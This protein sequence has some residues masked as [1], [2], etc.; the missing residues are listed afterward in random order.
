M[1]EQ[2]QP[3]LYQGGRTGSANGAKSGGPPLPFLFECER[4]DGDKLAHRALNHLTPQSGRQT[5]NTGFD[6]DDLH[7]AA[8]NSAW[9]LKRKRIVITRH[10]EIHH[11]W[12][13]DH[14]TDARS[15]PTHY[16]ARKMPV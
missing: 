15:P 14:M 13:R 16:R 3:E 9:R 10:I 2:Q 12:F 1:Q 7:G 6:L 11:C 8:A 5:W 4:M